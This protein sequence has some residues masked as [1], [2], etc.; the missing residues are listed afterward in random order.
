MPPTLYVLGGRQRALRP[1]TAGNQDWY[2]YDQAVV[3][4]LDPA[5]GTATR[6]FDYVS[7]P[8]ATPPVNPTIL[9]KSGTRVGDLLYLC[10]QTEIM[11]HRLPSFERELYLSLPFFNDLHHVRP[12]SRGTLLVAVTGLDMV[13]EL[14]PNGRVVHEWATLD[15]DTPYARFSRTIDYRH[16]ATTKPHLSH[17]NYVFEIGEDV[18]ATRFQQKD[19]VCLSR[20]GQRIEIGVERPHDGLVHE[21]H[22][23]FT[24]VNGR[25]LVADVETLK[26]VDVID[27]TAMHPK[28][29]LLGWCRGIMFEDGLLWVGFSRIRPTKIRENVGWIARGFKRDLGTHVGSYDLSAK[30]CVGQYGVED[31]GLSAI[32]SI[33][34]GPESQAAGGT[35]SARG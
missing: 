21:G 10:T 13:V 6:V 2:E 30:E 1:I 29:V 5:T 7:P 9:L 15:D 12:T 3:L 27:L 22:V 19:A 35:K 18:W 26:V 28:D 33:L 24:T 4:N 8:E 16:V 25:I 32:F 14:E 20:P 11:V 23:Y 34:P 17:P 31:Q